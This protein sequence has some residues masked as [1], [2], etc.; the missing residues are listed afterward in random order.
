[1]EAFLMQIF[2]NLPTIAVVLVGVIS[3]FSLGKGADL[4]VDHAVSVSRHFNI[5]KAIV[6]ATIVSLGTTLPEASVSVL[7]AVQG[8]PDLALGNA[9]GSVIVDTGL[10]IGIASQIAP[11]PIDINAIR[12]QSWTQFAVGILIVIFSLPFWHPGG[13]G[14]ISQWMGIIL[15]ILLVAYLYRSMKQSTSS[16]YETE[17]ITPSTHVSLD[18]LLIIIG[19]AIVIIASKVLIPSVEVLA[20]RA[21]IPESIIAATLV[22]F[23]TSLPELTTA[24]KSV[25]K[26]HSDLALGNI[27]GADILNILFVI[28][29][30]A[31]VTKEGLAVPSNFYSIQL[32]FLMIILVLFRIFTLNSGEQISR[33]EGMVLLVCY[34]IYLAFNYGPA[35]LI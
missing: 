29:A 34:L 8:V 35:L 28:G 33:M 16:T 25:T 15:I 3:L 18:F 14:N 5:P 17:E 6:G 21:G 31:A 20:I 19:I 10:I 9:I 2:S 13:I 1:M 24:I 32:P 4:L 26:G 7:A 12:F 11:L 27:M 22:A 30:A 23:G